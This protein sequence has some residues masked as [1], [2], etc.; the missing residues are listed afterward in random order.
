MFAVLSAGLACS[1]NTSPLT[2]ST[3]STA[4]VQV[5]PTS[6]QESQDQIVSKICQQQRASVSL[7]KCGE[8]YSAYPTGFVVDAGTDIFDKNGDRIDS[9][10]G[11]RFFVS[12]EARAEAERKCATYLVGCTRVVDSC[13]APR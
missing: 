9:C 12:D 5:A 10:G 11:N 2:G 8:F 6:G 7:N 4:P 1:A 3:E 13:G